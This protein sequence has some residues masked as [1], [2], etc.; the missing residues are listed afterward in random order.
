[1][2]ASNDSGLLFDAWTDADRVFA[3]LTEE[4][5]LAQYEG[6]S[7]FGWTLAHITASMD[8]WINVRFQ[9]LERNALLGAARYRYGGTGKADGWPEIVAAVASVRAGVHGYLEGLPD[10]ALLT[11]TSPYSGANERLKGTQI[12]LRYFVL[13]S[14]AHHYFHIGEVASKRDRLGHKVGDYPGPLENTM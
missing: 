2:P 1:M 8:Q 10:E 12:S 14:I 9:N 6:G 5:A 7:S 4:E 3:R 13:R 11:T